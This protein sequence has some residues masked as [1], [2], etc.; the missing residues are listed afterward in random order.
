M[1]TYRDPSEA[2]I[3]LCEFIFQS[4]TLKCCL[5]YPASNENNHLKIVVRQKRTRNIHYESNTKE[6]SAHI[7]TVQTLAHIPFSDLNKPIARTITFP[8]TLCNQ[9]GRDTLCLLRSDYPKPP[10]TT[11]TFP[12][13]PT[14]AQLATN[15]LEEFL[16][17]A[18]QGQLQPLTPYILQ[19][20]VHKIISAGE[21]DPPPT[22]STQRNYPPEILINVLHLLTAQHPKDNIAVR[23]LEE[24]WDNNDLKI[25]Y[26]TS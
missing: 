11:H 19:L 17:A 21:S 5:Q 18:T 4:K 10:R 26:S 8:R 25:T 22:R 14:L 15:S 12:S 1:A 16:E 24:S 20:I 6:P 9:L 2:L 7:E 23:S 3:E 13:M